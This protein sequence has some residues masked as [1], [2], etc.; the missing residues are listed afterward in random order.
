[1]KRLAIVFALVI[2]ACG[3]SEGDI[4]TAIVETE[5]AAILTEV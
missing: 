1:M 4:Q 3:A 2:S 5:N